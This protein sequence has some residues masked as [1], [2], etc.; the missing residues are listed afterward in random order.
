MLIAE[1][2]LGRL[3]EELR[4]LERRDQELLRDVYVRG[5]SRAEVATRR[6]VK[7]ELVRQRLLRIILKLR[8]RL[9]DVLADPS[10]FDAARDKKHGG[11]A[12][13]PRS[14]GGG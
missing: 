1:E 10:R 9:S 4:R 14:R 2:E 7:P 8:A 5:V 11:Q 6:G 13:G 12:A 3:G